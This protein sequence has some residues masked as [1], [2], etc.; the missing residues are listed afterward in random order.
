M[1]FAFRVDE[2]KT[3]NPGLLR[4]QITWERKVPAASPIN[5]YGEDVFV[6]SGFQVCRAQVK[7]L[8]GREL[9][10]AQQRWAEAKY[11]ILQHY[12]KGLE[13][14]DR[15]YWW[16]DGEAVYLDPLSID[17]EPGTGYWQQV[18]CKERIP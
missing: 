5:S 7:E 16:I 1:R 6:W 8:T 4:H 2:G 13:M 10:S 12:I 3:P 18:V 15:I 11:V 17:D 9:E 14:T